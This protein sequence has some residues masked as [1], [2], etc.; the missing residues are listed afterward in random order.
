M[1]FITKINTFCFKISILTAIYNI[2]TNSYRKFCD[3]C[4]AE[5]C[6]KQWWKTAIIH[7][8]RLCLPWDDSAG[9]L[10]RLKPRNEHSVTLCEHGATRCNFR[11]WQCHFWRSLWH[12]SL[13]QSR[14]WCRLL[15]AGFWM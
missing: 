3:N 8:D 15:G 4:L 13:W 1:H 12:C 10:L 6:R 5:P 7:R 11:K 2:K 14:R 9:R